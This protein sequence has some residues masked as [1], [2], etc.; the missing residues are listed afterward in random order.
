MKKTR[1]DQDPRTRVRYAAVDKVISMPSSSRRK[2]NPKPQKGPAWASE[3]DKN[4]PA[5]AFGASDSS[6]GTS[7]FLRDTVRWQALIKLGTSRI[8]TD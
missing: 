4:D 8:G 3:L 1:T 7:S 2:E 5:T 6:R